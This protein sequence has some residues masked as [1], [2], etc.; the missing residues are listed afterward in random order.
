MSSPRLSSVLILLTLGACGPAADTDGDTDAVDTGDTG[1]SGSACRTEPGPWSSA[2]WS[3]STVE[4]LA[5]R[6]QLDTLVGADTMRGAEQGAVTVDELADLTGPF[7]A[8]SPSLLLVTTPAYRAVVEDAFEDF[9]A[10]VTS[11]N[12]DLFDDGGAW[13]PGT[14]GGITPEGSRGMNTGGLEV[15]QFVEKGL[16]AGGAFYP[17]A[18]RLTADDITPDTVDAIAALWGASETLD[19]EER[20]DAASYSHAMGYFAPIAE[21]LTQAQAY[22]GDPACGAERDAALVEV[23]RLW[24]EAMAGRAVYYAGFASEKFTSAGSEADLVDA[25]H[26]FA[27]GVA[28]VLSFRELSAPSSGPLAGAARVITDAQI[29][30]ILSAFG[31]DRTDLGASTT[32]SFVT[33]AAGFAAAVATAEG[34]LKEAYGLSDAELADW[35]SPTG[36]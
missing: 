18:Q 13:A 28:L 34:V 21:A 6:A 16:Y 35:R 27:E 11:G 19:P 36:G 24:E 5:L 1:D 2:G 8:G 9:V 30:A 17:W 29:D 14:S 12:T 15:R 7:E 31:V 10:L 20:T 4:A 33:D 22:A 25:L 32:G 3:T 26:E 23:F